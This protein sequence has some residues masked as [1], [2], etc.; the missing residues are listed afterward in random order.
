MLHAILLGMFKYMKECFFLQIGET[1][2]LA[3]EINALAEQYG[4]L[5]ACQSNCN[6]P[7]TKFSK[8][9]HGK[10]KIMVKEYTGV[11]LLMAT[12]LHS[13]RAMNF[14][15]KERAI[16]EPIISFTTGFCWWRPYYSGNSG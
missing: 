11:L 5:L 7:K 13:S 10:G 3:Q 2:L 6:M 14:F 12:V 9:I 4:E 1:S 16:L 8:G 15:A